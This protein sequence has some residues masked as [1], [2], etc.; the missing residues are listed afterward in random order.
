MDSK[1]AAQ[2]LEKYWNCETSLEEE[3][4]LREYFRGDVPVEMKDAAEL[5]RYFEREQGKSLDE[6][7]DREIVRKLKTQTGKGKVISMLSMT[8]VA[9]IAAGLIVVVA[10]TYL[11]GREVRKN[12]PAEV[13]DTY[14][15]PKLALEETKKALMMI[16]KGF[17]KA[18]QEAGKINMFN[19]AEQKIQGKEKSK[20]E[21]KEKINI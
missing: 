15:D 1:A 16:S 3:K 2:L 18:K 6:T 20:A 17:G 8:Q 12:Y 21:V 9:R 13:V 10:A 14:S 5:F 7:F 11:I 4:Q 19:E